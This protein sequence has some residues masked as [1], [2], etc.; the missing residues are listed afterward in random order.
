MTIKNFPLAVI[1]ARRARLMIGLG[2]LLVAAPAL[3]A[4]AGFWTYPAI[5]GIGPVHTWPGDT[6]M[7]DKSTTYKAV[8]DLTKPSKASDKVSPALTHIARA[9]NVF[10]SA[11]VPLDHLKFVVIAHG[12]ATTDILNDKAYE[13]K[14]HTH[15]PNVEVL[16]ALHKAG[17]ELLVCG[18]A[19]ADNHLSPADTIDY[20]KP[21]LSALSTLVILQNQGYALMRF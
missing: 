20:V 4:G 19:L 1:G 13:A 11:G 17:V 9:V 5:K 7:P 6:L 3:A 18:N 21:A 14:F 10:A 2:A 15:N 8:F 12:P 16:E